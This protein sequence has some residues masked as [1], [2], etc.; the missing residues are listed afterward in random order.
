MKITQG[1]LFTTIE[2]DEGFILVDKQTREGSFLLYLGKN[3]SPD[4]Y[5]EIPT[6]EYVEPVFEDFHE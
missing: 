5:E 2:P 1:M 3:D 6:S 4:N